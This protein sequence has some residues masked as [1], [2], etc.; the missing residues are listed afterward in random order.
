MKTLIMS[1]LCF[2]VMTVA[3]SA[4]QTKIAT[5]V[6]SASYSIGWDIG[7]SLKAQSISITPS[8]LA[9]GILDALEGKTGALTNDQVQEIIMSL[10]EEMA[11]KAQGH[12]QQM[13]EENKRAGDAFLA[14]NKQKKGVVTLPSGLQYEVVKEGNGP[15]PKAT[16]KVTVHYTGRL[17]DGTVFDS[18]IER[19]EP[20]SFQVNGVI[21]GWTEALQ[22]MKTGSQWKLFIPADL[23]YGAQGAGGAIGPNAVLVF[24]VELL[25]VN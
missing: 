14:Q 17:I 5:R 9:Q 16:D 13:G 20:T 8:L 15:L 24:D 11:A 1:A 25:K 6:D 23:A 19:G 21:R 12:M 4:Q 18:S 2:G 3:A 22:L 7:N 10:R